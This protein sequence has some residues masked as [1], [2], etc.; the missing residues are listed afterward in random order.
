MSKWFPLFFLFN[1]FY[2]IR[3]IIFLL[4]WQI[5]SF[6]RIV[7]DFTLKEEFQF[8]C[9]A[10]LFD[11]FTSCLWDMFRDRFIVFLW[12]GEFLGKWLLRGIWRRECLWMELGNSSV[13]WSLFLRSCMKGIF[14]WINLFW[15]LLLRLPLFQL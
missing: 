10:W 3:P 6:V 13:L 5:R 8:V 14:V 7:L 1:F 9:L 2:Y 11:I 4:C 12:I 15:T